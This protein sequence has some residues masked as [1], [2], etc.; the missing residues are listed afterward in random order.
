MQG[1]YTNHIYRHRL[2]GKH[3]KLG[4]KH[5]NQIIKILVYRRDKSDLLTNQDGPG[6]SN[7]C[8]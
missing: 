6:K 7:D 3:K 1:I 5:S 4:R 8:I 2:S